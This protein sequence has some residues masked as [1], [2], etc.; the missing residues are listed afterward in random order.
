MASYKIFNPVYFINIL[1]LL[2]QKNVEST[3]KFVKTAIFKNPDIYPYNLPIE[4][5]K[6][7]EN[8]VK[9]QEFTSGSSKI[10]RQKGN[11]GVLLNFRGVNVMLHTCLKG[12]DKVASICST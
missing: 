3:D 2:Y 9:S 1:S 10:R 4:E 6:A 12:C 7:K 5:T 11:Q 8:L